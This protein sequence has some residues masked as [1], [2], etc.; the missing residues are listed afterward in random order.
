MVIVWATAIALGRMPRLNAATR[1]AIWWFALGA[2]LV[3][4]LVQPDA[5]V[6]LSATVPTGPQPLWFP[7]RVVAVLPAP[8]WLITCAIAIWLGTAVAGL[9]SIASGIRRLVSL[10]ARSEPLPRARHSRLAMWSSLR[11]PGPRPDLRVSDEARGASALGLGRPAILLSRAWV[12]ALSDEDLDQIVMHEH[13]H[14]ARHDDWLRLLQSVIG[15]VAGL[16]PA[17][18]FALHR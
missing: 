4:P 15:S 2:V 1:H 7:T 10:K 9:V 12:D 13:A 17:V 14:L 18:R 5:L 3:L 16:H 8:D 11:D 6:R